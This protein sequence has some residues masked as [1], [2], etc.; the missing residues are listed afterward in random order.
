VKLLLQS[1]ISRFLTCPLLFPLVG[2]QFLCDLLR[3]PIVSKSVP[4]HTIVT[5]GEDA[6]GAYKY[7]A[8]LC[9]FSTS[10]VKVKL[11]QFGPFNP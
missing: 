9:C 8:L 1:Q 4:V 5:G 10:D 3:L 2:Q 11:S 6:N 7:F